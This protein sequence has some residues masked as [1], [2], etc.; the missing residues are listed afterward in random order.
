MPQSC[1]PGA[2]T[3][4]PPGCSGVS[5]AS[6]TSGTRTHL[7]AHLR[8]QLTSNDTVSSAKS[9][10][11][12]DPLAIS[13]DSFS[14]DVEY[15]MSTSGLWRVL[16]YMPLHSREATSLLNVGVA[17]ASSPL[18]RAIDGQ[19]CSGGLLLEA[20][21]SRTAA[22]RRSPQAAHARELQRAGHPLVRLVGAPCDADT[23][24]SMDCGERGHEL[25]LV[26][27]CTRGRSSRC[28]A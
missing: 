25:Q 22:A 17:P 9:M 26:R 24:R 10:S 2:Q 28:P 5:L 20:L 21:S 12:P 18:C 13:A 15:S 3:C 14:N 23:N 27:I 16:P 1:P 7:A 19:A 4:R 6:W 8:G 11:T